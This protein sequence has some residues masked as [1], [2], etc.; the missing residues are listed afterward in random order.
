MV[1]L[2]RIKSESKNC[3]HFEVWLQMTENTGELG[4]NPIIFLLSG[5]SIWFDIVYFQLRYCLQNASNPWDR[6]I[7]PQIKSGIKNEEGIFKRFYLPC[8][9]TGFTWLMNGR[10]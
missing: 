3:P 4:R 10:V 8:H 9:E 1:Y 2:I 6:A 7:N 5:K